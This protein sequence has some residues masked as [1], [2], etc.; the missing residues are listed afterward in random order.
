MEHDGLR[1]LSHLC[2]IALSENEITTFQGHIERL[3]EYV[4]LLNEVQTDDLQPSPH[5]ADRGFNALRD[6]T[7]GELLPRKEFL[8][9]APDSVGGMVRFPPVFKSEE[10]G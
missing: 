9:N 1:H 2:R 3:L 4:Q 5:V 8:A 6:D 7:P 10:G